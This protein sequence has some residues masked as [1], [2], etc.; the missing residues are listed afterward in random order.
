MASILIVED[1]KHINDMIAK[2]LR[3]V[4]HSCKQAYDGIAG[5][6]TASEETFGLILADIM[7]PGLSG[8]DLANE[9][10]DTP[11]IFITAKDSVQDKVAGFQHG[12]DDYIVKPFE[13]LEL[14]ERV[15]A[16][17]RRTMKIDNI[18]TFQNVTVDF[19]SRKITKNNVS[20]E[21][22]PQEFQLLEVL[23]TKNRNIALCAINF[24]HWHGAMII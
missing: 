6:H 12:A 5:L 11:V 8:F 3:V 16:V 1:D 19:L 22:T 18:F 15:N 21:I 9:I 7:L 10:S 20:V 4:G 14:I 2:N 17:L 23:I 13:M 24:S